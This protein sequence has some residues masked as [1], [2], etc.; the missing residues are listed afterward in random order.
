MTLHQSVAALLLLMSVAAAQSAFAQKED[1]FPPEIPKVWDEQALATWATPVAGLNVRP[2]HFSE[3][4]YYRAPIDN[5]RTYPVYAPGR[6]PAGYWEMLQK[7]GPKPLIDPSKLRSKRDWLAAGQ[8]VFEQA[9]HLSLR[10][11]DP[12]VIT[13]IRSP[14]MLKNLPYVSPDGTLR[15][16]RWV[17][18]EKGVAIGHLNCGSCHTRE[19]PDGTRLN[20]PPARGEA[21]NPIRRLVGAEDVA[22]SPFHIAES[23]GEKM[24]R[25]FGAPWVKDDAHERLKQMSQDELAALNASVGLAKGVIPRWNGSVF[26]PAKVPDLI[27]VADRK[28]L[29]H[30]GTHANRGIGDLM[31]YAAL[32]SYAESAEFGSHQMLAPEQRKICGRLPDEAFYALALYIQSLQPPP[33]PNRFDESARAGQQIFAREGCAGCHT[34]GLYTNNKL[35]LA[36]GFTP[37]ADRPSTID[38]IAI[39]VGTDP[40]LALKTRKGTGYYK[41]PSL[42]GVWYRGHFMHDGS[43]ASLEEMFDPDRLKDTHEPGG[44][45]PPG[46]RARAVPGHEFGLRLNR[47][48]KASLIAFLKTL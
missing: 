42:R 19:E 43:I 8:A 9:D 21:S 44:W 17:P 11:W 34:P 5:Y 7:V 4:E 32:I 2:G 26:F 31:R 33:N 48:E 28:Y 15:L 18:T 41:V 1:P 29:D 47:D 14:A 39:S 10:S 13:V 3:P 20:G 16:L 36:K 35:T 6:E 40:N 45:N 25:A 46:V 27:G 12:K 24:Y 37:P 38:L 30:T 22:N 23:L